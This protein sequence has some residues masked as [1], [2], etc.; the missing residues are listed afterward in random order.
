MTYTKLCAVSLHAHDMLQRYLE[1]FPEDAARLADASAQLAS[2]GEKALERATMRGHVTTSA[3]IF[4]PL[5]HKVLLI[6]HRIYDKWFPP[7]GH[8]ELPGSLWD[9]AAR[10]VQ[11]ETGVSPARHPWMLHVDIP[12]DVD[13]HQIGANAKKGEGEHF[14]HDFTFL[15][16]ASSEVPLVPQAEEVHGAKWVSL[17][18]FL[19]SETSRSR[20]IAQRLK[21]LILNG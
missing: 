21:E 14:H 12:L 10:E 15:G 7:G 9:S 2:D 13:T 1:H 20:R 5:T 16:T 8:Y 4:D 3:L 18:D 11:E 19:Q 17:E 6:H